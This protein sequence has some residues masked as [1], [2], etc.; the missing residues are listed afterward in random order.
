M[1]D[2]PEERTPCVFKMIFRDVVAEITG[3]EEMLCHD[4]PLMEA[5]LDSIAAVEF[6]H[7]ITPQ[8]SG[9][10]LPVVIAFD[11]PTI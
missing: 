2:W 3:A 5:G 7:R 4:V 11:P 8:F 6:R 1:E 10:C 9:V